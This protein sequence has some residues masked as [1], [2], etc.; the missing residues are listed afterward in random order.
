MAVAVLDLSRRGDRGE[1]LA[2]LAAELDWRLASWIAAA[3]A[4][5][6]DQLLTLATNSQQADG[7]LG[8]TLRARLNAQH[9]GLPVELMGQWVIE[10]A[11]GSVRCHL[12]LAAGHDPAAGL[13]AHGLL[14]GGRGTSSSLVSLNEPFPLSAVAASSLEPGQEFFVFCFGQHTFSNRH[15]LPLL[16]AKDVLSG[17]WHLALADTN[18]VIAAAAWDAATAQLLLADGLRSDFPGLSHTILS[19]PAQWS[20]LTPG[21]LWQDPLPLVQWLQ[22]VV[23]PDA[24]GVYGRRFAHLGYARA[25]DGSGWLGLGPTPLAVR[26]DDPT[27]TPTPTEVP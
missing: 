20:P 13:G 24:L 27:T 26:M 10:L 19:R 5:N 11:T 25:V 14:S 16:I 23:L 18:G 3:N 8:W 15:G 1:P 22:P 7:W 6:P 4:Q 17:Q 21:I 2:E 12:A 9:N